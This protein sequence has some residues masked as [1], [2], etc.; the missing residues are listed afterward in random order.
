MFEFG[1]DVVVYSVI[2][3]IGGYGDVVVGVIICKMKV[4]VEK[5]CLMWKDIGGIMV[6]FDVWLL[7]CGLKMLVVRM[8]C[9]CDNVEKI[10]LFL[11]KYDVVEGVWY[12]EGELVFC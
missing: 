6:L 8:D 3:Y 10:V 4:L 11:R 1:C 2:K 7:L 12:L 5:I 9:Y